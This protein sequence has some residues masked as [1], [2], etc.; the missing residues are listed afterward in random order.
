M[1]ERST[2]GL[3]GKTGSTFTI[4]KPVVLIVLATVESEKQNFE[5]SVTGND[6]KRGRFNGSKVM[7][8]FLG[9]STQ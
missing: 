8:E 6:V 9:V 3:G 7:G 4:A 1:N 2:V 5:S